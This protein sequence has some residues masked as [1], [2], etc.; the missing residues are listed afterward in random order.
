MLYTRTVLLAAL[1]QLH[2]VLAFF[3]ISVFRS[4][5]IETLYTGA[6]KPSYI[7]KCLFTCFVTLTTQ[8]PLKTD[9]EQLA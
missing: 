1:L 2:A 5:D 7:I 9:L 8:L 6:D 4:E 3:G